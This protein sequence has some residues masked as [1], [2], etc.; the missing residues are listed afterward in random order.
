M[1]LHRIATRRVL[2]RVGFR[3]AN[4]TID[5]LVGHAAR[6][7]DR[8]RLLLARPLVLRGNRENA[9]RVDVERHLDLGNA[10]GSTLDALQTEFADRLV[11][12]RHRA[13]ALKH[14]DF[15]ARL[16]RRRGREDLRVMHGER[17]VALHD[18]R[19][20]AADGLKGKGKRRHVEQQDGVRLHKPRRRP[21]E[22]SPLD[23]RAHGDALVGVD[24]RRRLLPR[25]GANLVLN[26]RD[27]RRPADK[28]HAS[29]LGGGNAR[30]VER[31]G[32]G[33]FGALNQI[34]G[35]AV[36]LRARD[37]RLQMK[38][39]GC[40]LRQKRQVHAR[41]L[42][43]GQLLFRLARRLA[44][45]LRRGGIA[46]RVDARF[47]LEDPE[48]V[49]G[50]ALV[51]VVATQ[52]VVAR[53]RKH[54]NHALADLDDRHIERA[55]AQV[56]DHHL[57]RVTVVEPVRERRA[58]RLVDDAQDF[59]PRD[60][61]RILCG[62]AL[63]IVEVGGDGDDSLRHLLAEERLSVAAQLAQNHR[64]DFLR[65]ESFTVDART[66]VGSHVALHRGDSA[67]GVDC[68]LPTS[69]RTDEALAIFREGDDARRRARALGVVD[70]GRLAAL[71]HRGATVRRA[72]VN[73]DSCHISLLPREQ[74][75]S[76]K[77]HQS[78]RARHITP[79]DGP[80]AP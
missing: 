4:G 28:Q 80:R 25:K 16:E 68:R 42:H 57:L 30:V 78:Q 75:D 51:E 55:T 6:L 17:R 13:L 37:L 64:G 45:A 27:A 35:H 60:A 52:M 5:F 18:A 31:L 79:A 72:Q 44:H 49:I 2:R 36:E 21:R 3:I 50:D 19:R 48:Q 47:P 12:A 23:G 11:V 39:A 14:V 26:R 61:A 41:R 66:P 10:R 70:D 65:R 73:P 63:H 74:G 77:Q 76:F 59:E 7:V 38:R 29:Q 46:T 1:H 69:C 22:R 62:L 53:S 32:H 71:D 24:R 8:D 43:G 15:H 9:V 20:H 40:A 56:V 58:C 54:L 67:L 34:G 33:A